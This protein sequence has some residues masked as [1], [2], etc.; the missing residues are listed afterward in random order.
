MGHPV[1]YL[2]SVFS[3]KKSIIQIIQ[4]KSKKNED[5]QDWREFQTIVTFDYIIIYS[6]NQI[7]EKKSLEN[8]SE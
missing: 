3:D 5:S 1:Y 2:L 6:D 7:T 8:L 4:H